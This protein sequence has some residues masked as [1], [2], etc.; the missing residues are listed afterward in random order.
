MLFV[1]SRLDL[2]KIPKGSRVQVLTLMT[3]LSG[4]NE[5]ILFW[6]FHSK[7]SSKLDWPVN[8]SLSSFIIKKIFLAACFVIESSKATPIKQ[9]KNVFDT[10]H[11]RSRNENQFF[12][13]LSSHPNDQSKFARD[14]FASWQ[15]SV[16]ARACRWKLLKALL[17]QSKHL[18]MQM[19]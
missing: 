16:Y 12:K 18:F 3:L 2:C 14:F 10:S 15:E 8:N 9:W 6:R 5:N 17:A 7:L 13:N 11:W 4:I 1:L 19:P